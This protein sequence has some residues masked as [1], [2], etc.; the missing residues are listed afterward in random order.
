MHMT[1]HFAICDDEPAQREN[2]ERLARA[3]AAANEYYTRVVCFPSAEAFLFRYAED[4]SFDI[5][6]LDI[7][8]AGLTGVDLAREVRAGDKEA[9]IIFV[10]GFMDYIADGYDV[11]ALHYLLKP[12][13][14]AKLFAVL[15]RAAAKLKENERALILDLGSESARVPLYEIKYLEVQ[16][17]YVT[18]RAR[19]D[20]TVKASLSEYEGQLSKNFLRVGR[21][22]IVNLKFVRRVTRGEIVLDGDA[23]VPMPRGFYDTVNRALIERL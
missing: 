22:Y 15:D 19:E 6:L 9:Q 13:D 23:R 18:V 4:K 11:E 2:L 8:M 7:E 14:E 21:S 20:Y 17:N 10:T 16:K 1:Y 3:W 12:V 5:L